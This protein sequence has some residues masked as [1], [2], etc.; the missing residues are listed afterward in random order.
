RDGKVKACKYHDAMPSVKECEWCGNAMC[1]TC[2]KRLNGICRDCAR[3]RLARYLTSPPPRNQVLKLLRRKEHK[4]YLLVLLPL[5]LLALFAFGPLS[6]LAD[7]LKMLLFFVVMPLSVIGF[8][9]WVK[10]LLASI[11]EIQRNRV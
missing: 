3:E 2:Y 7:D 9:V 4:F 8:E 11:K 5:F 1:T 10:L 6:P